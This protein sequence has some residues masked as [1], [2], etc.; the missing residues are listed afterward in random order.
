MS[1]PRTLACVGAAV[2][3]ISGGC[4]GDDNDEPAPGAASTTEASSTTTE[5]ETTTEEVKPEITDEGHEGGGP[6]PGSEEA[7][8][9][10]AAEDSVE[11]GDGEASESGSG[12]VEAE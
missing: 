2:A 8:A 9:A 5:L 10:D 6:D 12:G 7:E 1:R 11:T 4:G 3:A